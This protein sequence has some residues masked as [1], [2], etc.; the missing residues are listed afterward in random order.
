MLVREGKGSQMSFFAKLSIWLRK[1]VIKL[2]NKPTPVTYIGAGR[3]KEVGGLLFAMDIKKVLI[4]TDRMLRKLGLLDG[5]LA[6]IEAEGIEAAIFD[7]VLPDPTFDVVNEAE[8]SYGDCEAIV[9]VGGGSVLDTAKAVGAAVSSGKPAA[10]LAG[11][12]KVKK[13]LPPF[14]AVPTTAGTGSETTVA[15][16]ISDP[17]THTKKQLLDPKLV[18]SFAVLDASLTVG[19]PPHTTAHTALD[20]LT[21]ALEAI[22]ADYADGETNQKAFMAVR[23]IYENLPRVMENPHD[24]KAREALLVASFFGG[25]A[26][27]RTYVG[28]VHAYAHTVG[29]RY[30]IPHGLANAVL[31]PH[32]MEYYLPVC[33]A[34][35]A[36]LGELT[37]VCEAGDPTQRK[38]RKFVDSL[39][40]LNRRF[41]IP[42]RF[43]KFPA[44][45][46][47]EVIAAA[48]RECHGVYPVPR[49]YSRGTARALLEKVCAL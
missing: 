27:T 20:A 4:I 48:F 22:V 32:V 5:L 43:E 8:Q 46:I 14:I 47:D 3:V 42:Q 23:M 30:G 9:A 21:H 25:M 38:A 12:L 26:F 24:L 35:F 28:Y 16:V 49:Y 15:A 37:G 2:V 1:P 45:D 31:L 29:G 36:R 17:S 11:L 41:L 19:L 7:G 6:G 44:G 10:G 18:P 39:F 33:A 40:L 13:H 34:H